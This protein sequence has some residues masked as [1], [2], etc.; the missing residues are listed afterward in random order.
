MPVLGRLA[1]R[2]AVPGEPRSSRLRRGAAR[3][4]VSAR[5]SFVTPRS[6][7]SS[8]V[9]H[10]DL[11]AAERKE[12]VLGRLYATVNIENETEYELTIRYSGCDSFKVVF[13]PESLNA[14]IGW[15]GR[16][17]NPPQRCSR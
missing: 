9:K 3:P 7:T 17:S 8:R 4:Q 5:F 2:T 13:K 16:G 15:R 10:G 14:S 12:A 11:P 1:E 6:P